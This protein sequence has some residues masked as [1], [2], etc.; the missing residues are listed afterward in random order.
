MTLFRCPGPP[1]GCWDRAGGLL[2]CTPCG[3]REPP[4]WLREA[5]LVWHRRPGAGGQPRPDG[6]PGRGDDPQRPLRSHNPHSRVVPRLCHPFRAE[7]QHPRPAGTG[8]DVWRSPRSSQSGVPGWSPGGFGVS[9][10]KETSP[11]LWALGQGSLTRT[12]T[13]CSGTLQPW[14]TKRGWAASLAPLPLAG[15]SWVRGLATG[16]GSRSPRRGLS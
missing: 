16:P 2:M 15:G 4:C 12:D 6:Q 11:P 9:P 7:S 5:R 3:W 10:E 1:T 13:L 14:G 8:R